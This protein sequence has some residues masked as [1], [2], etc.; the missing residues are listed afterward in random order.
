MLTCELMPTKMFCST[1]TDTHQNATHL[2]NNW[3]KSRKLKEQEGAAHHSLDLP[4]F[5]C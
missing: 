3:T 5:I 2:L 4:E 1:Q